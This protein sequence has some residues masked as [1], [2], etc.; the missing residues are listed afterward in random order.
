MLY[1]IVTWLI[2]IITSWLVI[3]GS[4][5]LASKWF[6]TPVRAFLP[7]HQNKQGIPCCGGV[8]VTILMAILSPLVISWNHP[9]LW[10][11]EVG[12]VGFG[13]LGLI[14]DYYKIKGRHGIKSKVK[15]MAQTILALF[16]S[17]FLAQYLGK[18]F[19][20]LYLPGYGSIEMGEWAYVWS[21][22]VIVSSC[23]GINI[24]DGLDGLAT[25]VTLMVLIGFLCLN[26]LI[27]GSGVVIFTSASVTQYVILLTAVLSG[28]LLH[29]RYPAKLFLGDCGSLALGGL[30]GILAIVSKQEVSFVCF[31]VV[32]II[33]LLSVIAQVFSLKVF[34]RRVLLI[35]PLHHHFEK[36]KIPETKIVFAFYM[37]TVVGVLLGLGIA[38]LCR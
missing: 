32:P 6:G 5:P 10:L 18:D 1:D 26:W 29:N 38:N 33:E 19:Y 3:E 15:F 9:L 17:Y 34:K 35:S 13:L 12:F 14:D 31:M 25:G 21:I 11:L 16:I 7:S 4:L 24:S 30:L 36:K 20:Q 22:W 27:S 8:L 37:I 2:G 23:N 28:F